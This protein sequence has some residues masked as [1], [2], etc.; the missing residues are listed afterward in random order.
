MVTKDL[1]LGSILVR[2]LVDRE[3]YSKENLI[4]IND[5]CIKEIAEEAGIDKAHIK[6]LME[7]SN[8]LV[9]TTEQNEQI[10]RLDPN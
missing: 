6:G 4:R 2:I 7:K 8:K 1:G 5:K 10:I 3:I 9:Q